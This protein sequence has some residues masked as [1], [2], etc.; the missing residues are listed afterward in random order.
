VGQPER[1]EELPIRRGALE[2]APVS[3]E[4]NA[5]ERPSRAALRFPTVVISA[6]IGVTMPKTA[7]PGRWLG[8]LSL[9]V[10]AVHVPSALSL[11]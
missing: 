8:W 9:A 1:A 7:L 2:L 4:S 11:A 10:A 6:A 5:T 3:S